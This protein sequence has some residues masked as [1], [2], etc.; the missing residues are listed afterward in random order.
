MFWN[1]CKQI[2]N[3]AGFQLFDL[4]LL[5]QWLSEII[6]P[7]SSFCLA[8]KL[9]FTPSVLFIFMMQLKHFSFKSDLK[10][11]QI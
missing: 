11:N 3:G 7:V 2:Q 6:F 8:V 5:Q 4:S 10:L 9:V 1:G